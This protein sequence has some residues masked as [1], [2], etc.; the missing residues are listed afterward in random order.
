MERLAFT[1]LGIN[2]F[3]ALLFIGLKA[4]KEEITSAVG[5][6]SEWVSKWLAL[7]LIKGLGSARPYFRLFFC[8][9][10]RTYYIQQMD[11]RSPQH[12]HVRRS[13]DL[14]RHHHAYQG[15]LHDLLP[16]GNRL[17]HLCSLL[18]H[19]W[20]IHCWHLHRLAEHCRPCLRHS[21]TG[22]TCGNTG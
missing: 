20:L 22:V 7:I 17:D 21:S 8:A 1:M 6:V 9:F 18:D 16:L 19:L 13:L 4:D 12:H 11:S 2:L 5:W 14:P 10:L 15:Q 3:F